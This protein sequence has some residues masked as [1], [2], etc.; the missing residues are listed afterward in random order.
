LKRLPAQSDVR[1]SAIFGGKDNVYRYVLRRQWD[2][3]RPPCVFIGLNPSTADETHDDP[4]VRRCIGF[5]RAWG[6][7]ELVMLNLFAYRA[8]DPKNM[9]VAGY[10]VD[11]VGHQNDATIVEHVRR[12]KALGGIAIAA[13]GVHGTFLNRAQRVRALLHEHSV[14][15]VVWCLS[16]TKS[17]EPG[18]PL[19]LSQL[20]ARKPLP[21]YADG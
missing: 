13:W 2:D 18:H 5:A 19:Y 1:S 14:L 16:V 21:P 4:T 11:V 3:A 12:A 7:G 9:L 10:G 6:C 17:G 20:A 8:T 15:D